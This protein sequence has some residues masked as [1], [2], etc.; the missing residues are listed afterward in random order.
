[1]CIFNVRWTHA[2]SSQ[3]CPIPEPP[4][5]LQNNASCLQ[6]STFP[7]QMMHR[8][9]FPWQPAVWVMSSFNMSRVNIP[10]NWLKLCRIK[11]DAYTT[12][13][14]AAKRAPVITPQMKGSRYLLRQMKSFSFILYSAICSSISDSVSYV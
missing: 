13:A 3:R 8:F 7:L 1:M 2:P 14:I 6:H 12:C 10:L 5:S 11:Y 4:P 9:S